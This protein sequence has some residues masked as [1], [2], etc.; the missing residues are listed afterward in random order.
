MPAEEA[1]GHAIR[2]QNYQHISE[3]CN[4]VNDGMRSLDA[5]HQESAAVSH[6]WPEPTE[7]IASRLLHEFPVG[8]LYPLDF[9]SRRVSMGLAILAASTTLEPDPAEGLFPAPDQDTPND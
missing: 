5:N 4:A 3:L 1:T 6:P 8:K 9:S 7:V 2:S